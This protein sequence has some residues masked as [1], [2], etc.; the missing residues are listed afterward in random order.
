MA[1]SEKSGQETVGR[2]QQ[3][4]NQESCQR[5]AFSYQPKG[6]ERQEAEGSE[7]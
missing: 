4:S 5:S 2:K 1:Q 3:E 7:Q 6:R